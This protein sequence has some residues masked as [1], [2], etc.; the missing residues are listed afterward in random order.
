M[1]SDTKKQD[2]RNPLA[3]LWPTFEILMSPTGL[4]FRTMLSPFN[5]VTIN[6]TPWKTGRT[7]CE[8]WTSNFVHAAA[9]ILRFSVGKM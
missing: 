4:S 2:T 9:I 6:S 1:F 3:M 8:T 7:G 5:A